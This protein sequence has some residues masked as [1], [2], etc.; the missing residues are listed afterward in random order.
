M[1]GNNMET[2]SRILL[3]PNGNRNSSVS[4]ETAMETN[5]NRLP[6]AVDSKRKQL[7]SILETDPKSPSGNNPPSLKGVVTGPC[8]RHERRGREIPDTKQKGKTGGSEMRHETDITKEKM[9]ECL[10]RLTLLRQFPAN[11]HA[12]AEL[13]RTLNEL[14]RDD[15]D[16]TEFISAVQSRYD[17][18]PGPCSFRGVYQ[19]LTRREEQE[20]ERQQKLELAAAIAARAEHEAE[21]HGYS[22]RIDEETKTVFVNL[23]HKTFARIWQQGAWVKCRKGDDLPPEFCENRLA[24]ELVSHPGYLPWWSHADE[25]FKRSPA[26]EGHQ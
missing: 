25:G 26:T 4:M 11:S 24:E 19:E 7:V 6:Y 14:C 9:T 1:R 15:D 2:D 20:E 16:A 17:E 10:G 5:G 18:W 23:C 13:G 12:V 8:F 22:V 21:C 3:I